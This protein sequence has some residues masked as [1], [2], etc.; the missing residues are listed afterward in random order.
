MKLPNYWFALATLLSLGG[1]LS[2]AVLASAD[3][4]GHAAD[5]TAPDFQLKDLASGQTVSLQQLLGAEHHLLLVFWSTRCHVCQGMIPTFKRAQRDYQARGL[6]VVAINVGY[7]DEEE[8]INYVKRF[9]IDYQVLN[10]DAKKAQIAASYRL[11][12]T[13]TIAVVAPDGA[14]KYRGHRV[15]D[16]NALLPP[17]AASPQ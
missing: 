3:D 16:L 4:D 6:R 12:G 13:P 9:Q 7:E 15:P 5:Q 17:T 11:P 8:I 2:Q 1:W 14:V 10:D